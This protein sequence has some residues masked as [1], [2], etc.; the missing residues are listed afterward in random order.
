VARAEREGDERRAALDVERTPALR[1]VE[2]VPGDRE[3]IDFE[4][5]NADRDLAE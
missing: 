2:L 3:Q 5:S 4:I 1:R